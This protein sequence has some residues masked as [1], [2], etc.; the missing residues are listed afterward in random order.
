MRFLATVFFFLLCQKCLT[1][2]DRDISYMSSGGKLNPLQAIMDIRHYTLVLDVDIPNQTI[3]GYTE[4]E[5]VLSQ[6]TDTILFDMV[7]LLTV[8]NIQVEN[9]RKHCYQQ[10]DYIY[11]VDAAGFSA[12]RHK[13]KIEYGGIPPVAVRPPWKGGF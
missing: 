6:P 8:K 1:A 11:I 12:G 3:N 10:A 2:Q 7:H 5:L 4:I 13:I 9:N